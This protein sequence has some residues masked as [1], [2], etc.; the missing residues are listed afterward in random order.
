MLVRESRS[1]PAATANGQGDGRGG[2]ERLGGRHGLDG[3]FM[4]C[5]DMINLMIEGS[6]YCEPKVRITVTPCCGVE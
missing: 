4:R 6:A 1:A 5:W 2:E 3:A